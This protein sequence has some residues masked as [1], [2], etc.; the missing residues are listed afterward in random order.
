LAPA[1]R[2]FSRAIQLTPSSAHYLHE[3]SVVYAWQ[4]RYAEA[5]QVAI[6]AAAREPENPH[7][8]VHLAGIMTSAGD[9][10]G[11]ATTLEKA[12][13]LAPDNVSIRIAHNKALLALGRV[14]EATMVFAAFAAAYPDDTSVIGHLEFLQ[15]QPG[16]FA[17]QK[18]RRRDWPATAAA[19]TPRPSRAG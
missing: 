14:D 10:A 7:R 11:A 3:L 15:R 16:S 9:H 17:R 12:V 18:M 6:V 5:T 1:E 13:E 19:P 2:A 4:Q 8:L